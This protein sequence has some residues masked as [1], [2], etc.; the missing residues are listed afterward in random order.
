MTAPDRIWAVIGY[1]GKVTR[2]EFSSEQADCNRPCVEYT[3]TDS[4]P[5]ATTFAQALGL[6]EVQALVE[7]LR[8]IRDNPCMD[9]E[10]NSAIASAVLAD[11]GVR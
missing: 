1:V 10:G 4:T 8:E 7:S 3:R 9:P 6:P 11:L 5:S 2:G